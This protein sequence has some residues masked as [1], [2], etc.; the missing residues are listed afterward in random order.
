[1]RTTGFSAKLASRTLQRDGWSGSSS[2]SAARGNGG[3]TQ[4]E[5]LDTACRVDSGL[6]CS[7][8]RMGA[9]VTRHKK[10]GSLLQVSALFFLFSA[11]L[12]AAAAPAQS[13]TTPVIAPDLAARL[14]KYKP[15]KMPFDSSHLSDREKQMVAKLVDAAGLLDCVY[16][17]QSDPEGLKLYVSLANSN[18]SRDQMLRELLK[19]NGGRYN[20]INNGKPF[21]GTEPAPPGRGFFLPQ[22][23][24]Q[25]LD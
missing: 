11:F 21:V 9:T 20:Q 15:V 23:T 8:Q 13:P 1:M 5:L 10:R 4:R 12:A 2:R 7:K 25:H 18:D 17:R 14:A 3:T 16:W 24:Q 6:S 19:I 22:E